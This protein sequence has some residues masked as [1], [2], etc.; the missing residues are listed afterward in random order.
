MLYFAYGS[1]L[2]TNLLAIHLTDC[3]VDPNGVQ[4]S[5]PAILMDHKLRTNYFSIAHGA[6][7]CN[8]EPAPGNVVEGVV[9][10]VTDSIREVLRIKEGHPQRYEEIE[11]EVIILPAKTKVT[12]FTYIVIATQRLDR[13]QPVSSEYRRV[14]LDGAKAVGLNRDNCLYLR[15]EVVVELDGGEKVAAWTYEFAQPQS[16]CDQPRVPTQV[17]DGIPVHE[18][19]LKR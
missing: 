12:T 3:G 5:R 4:D 19:S 9:M 10:D 8:I 17:V 18:W 11:I 6:G 7:A 15:K 2:N 1:N 13:D 16:L 14:V